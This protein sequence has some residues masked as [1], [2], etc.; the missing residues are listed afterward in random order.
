MKPSIEQLFDAMSKF[1]I[2]VSRADYDDR[3]FSR[4]RTTLQNRF[5][6]MGIYDAF[7]WGK[8]PELNL[9]YLSLEIGDLGELGK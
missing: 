2:A 7:D 3:K 8:E 4:A 9:D 5:K 1:T 6:D